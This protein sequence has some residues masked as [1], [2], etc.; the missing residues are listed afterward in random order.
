MP[1]FTL[2][3]LL[4]AIVC[5]LIGSFP[6]GVVLTKRKYGIDVREM[7]S[8]NIGATNVTRVFGWYAGILTLIIDLA[9]SFF[10]LL[11]LKNHYPEDTWMLSI[12]ALS[13]VFGHCFS[14]YLK[15]RGGKGV[16]TALGAVAVV[17]PWCA[18]IA[19]G[20]YCIV[21]LVTKISALGS[22]AGIL[23]CIL[24]LTFV[25]VETSFFVLIISVC[26]LV[27]SRH[28]SNIKRLLEKRKVSK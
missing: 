3:H 19:T 11:Y 13:L 27:L 2:Q 15:F 14:I 17:A 10:P 20:V 21:I 18:V 28:T 5:Y 8:G 26:L 22:L 25:R 7:G 6:T 16:A 12:A 9:K 1:L 24:Y 4:V 23:S